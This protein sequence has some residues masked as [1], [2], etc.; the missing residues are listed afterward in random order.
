MDG[1]GGLGPTV[2]AAC[3]VGPQEEW[4]QNEVPT[5]V[6]PSGR[7]QCQ[8]TLVGLYDRCWWLDSAVLCACRGCRSAAVA[9]VGTK[10]AVS[11]GS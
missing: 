10:H 1:V 6:C 4:A 2:F 3:G 11:C 8:V 5:C 9:V 7:R